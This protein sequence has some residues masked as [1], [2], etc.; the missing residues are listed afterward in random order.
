[1][2]TEPLIIALG[3]IAGFCTTVAYIP[4]AV[5]TWRQ[6]GN[7]LSYGMLVLYLAGVF[8]WLFYGILVHAQAV[9]YTNV[10]TAVLIAIITGLKAWRAKV[11]H[12]PRSLP[13]EA[14]SRS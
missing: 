3:S 12:Q 7:D 4:Q 2:T 1:M 14:A 10:V 8:L 6:G 13:R 11:P 5:K 9:V